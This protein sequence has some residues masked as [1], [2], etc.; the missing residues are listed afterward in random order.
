MPLTLP[1][2]LP[3]SET[4]HPLGAPARPQS[5][6]GADHMPAL[7]KWSPMIMATAS[8]KMLQNFVIRAMVMARWAVTKSRINVQLLT[9]RE[10]KATGRKANIMRGTNVRGINTADAQKRYGIK[11][12]EQLI[13][14]I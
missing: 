8:A 10:R 1:E 3:F 9:K 6:S 12:R 2:Q 13:M 11:I 4:P 14:D 7:R 5:L